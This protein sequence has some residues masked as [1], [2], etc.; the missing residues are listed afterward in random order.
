MYFLIGNIEFSSFA[1]WVMDGGFI[2]VLI[3]NTMS[4]TR[5]RDLG[6]II[7][8]EFCGIKNVNF[9]DLTRKM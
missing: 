8:R 3:V 4:E 9:A 1:F 7:T 6:G 2:S 5:I